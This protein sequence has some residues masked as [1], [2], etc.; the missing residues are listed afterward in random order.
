MMETITQGHKSRF[1]VMAFS[2][3]AVLLS[4]YSD[5]ALKYCDR[6]SRRNNHSVVKIIC[7]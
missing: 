4:K 2:E 6:T 5:E 1:K 7:N 3:F